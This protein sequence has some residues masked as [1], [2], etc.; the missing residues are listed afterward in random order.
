MAGSALTIDGMAKRKPQNR[1]PAYVLYAR[2][3]P[4]LG[5]AF[6]RYLAVTKPTPT[7]TSAVELALERLL[8]AAGL[9]P[10]PADPSAES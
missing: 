5:E 8:E 2:I 10:P 4:K 7:A 9:W 1:A 6:E 3:D